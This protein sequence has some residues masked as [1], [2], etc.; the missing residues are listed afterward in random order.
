LFV[1]SARDEEQD[2]SQ[3]PVAPQ[4]PAVPPEFV[5][6]RVNYVQTVRVIVAGELDV[7]TVPQLDHA[8]RQAEA[9]APLVRLDLRRLEFVASCGVR[10]LLEVDARIR[11]A[12]GRFFVVDPPA[13][14]HRI[15]ALTG[16]TG[17]IDFDHDPLAAPGPPA[18]S[19]DHSA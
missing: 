17:K 9:D 19:Q 4:Q 3:E 12:G 15:L 16:N 7:A 1:A 13:E 11:R 8:L 10:L 14:V 18:A 2:V 6:L 5:C